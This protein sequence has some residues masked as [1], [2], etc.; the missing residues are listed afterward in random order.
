MRKKNR[1]VTDVAGLR[2]ILDR[3]AVC[4][5]ALTDGDAPYIVPL[6]FG[7]VWEDRLVLYFHGAKEGKKLDLIRAN[8]R[9]GFELDSPGA[10]KTGDRACDWSMNYESII[11]SGLLREVTDET[12]RQAGLT[13]VMRHYGRTDG[14]EYDPRVLAF[15]A[16]LRLDAEVFTGKRLDK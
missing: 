2:A 8:P 12:E 3:A 16:V 9:V 14:F 4:R 11:G 10:L 7:Y 6:N 15:T 1:E 13:A 5:I